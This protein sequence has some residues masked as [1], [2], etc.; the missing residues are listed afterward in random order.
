LVVSGFNRSS[1]PTAGLPVTALLQATV[2]A[3]GRTLTATADASVP[4][5]CASDDAVTVSWTLLPAMDGGDV[6]DISFADHVTGGLDGNAVDDP[7]VL[8]PAGT[9]STSRPWR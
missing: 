4:A 8:D 3:A 7:A 9:R 5:A 1:C 6:E 2:K